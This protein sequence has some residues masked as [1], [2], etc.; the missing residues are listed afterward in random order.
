[1]TTTEYQNVQNNSPMKAF[2][3][4]SSGLWINQALNVAAKLGVADFLTEGAKS[5]EELAQATETYAPSLYR[6]LRALASVG[7]FTE[8]EPRRFALTPVGE[9]L[10][11]DN[12]FSLRYQVMMHCSE[13]NWPLKGE[14]YRT[15]QDGKP[16]IQHIHQVEN[17][18]EY[19][20]GHPQ[21][22]E[23]FFRA[24][25]GILKN[26]CLPLLEEYDLSGFTKVVGAAGPENVAIGWILKNN[27]T[28]QG[29]LFG[30]PPVIAEA[31]DY[32]NSEGVGNQCETVEGDWSTSVPA[33]AGLYTLSYTM[34]E[35]DDDA[36]L[37][38]LQNLRGAVAE[39]G[40]VLVMDSVIAPGNE[41]DW[42]K[43]LDLEEMTMGNWKVRTQEEFNALF[44][45]AGFKLT[46]VIAKKEETAA[47]L[48]ELVPA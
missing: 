3:E 10:R 30:P 33:G 24:V 15:I 2:V 37:K 25:G 39:N 46:R 19:L 8:V 12:P 21:E 26:F 42:N 45:K 22:A 27:P 47:S 35:S 11:E 14:M 32:L 6:L 9:Y 5:V 44:E 40:K 38:I 13:C 16:T 48:M 20:D 7:V 41:H 1:M 36:A 31:A 4:L 23:L 29:I 18:M 43:W 28:M 17:Y 34:I